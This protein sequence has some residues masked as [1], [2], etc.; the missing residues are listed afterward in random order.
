MSYVLDVLTH[1][2]GTVFDVIAALPGVVAT[3]PG[4][5][6]FTVLAIVVVAAV[7]YWKG[8]AYR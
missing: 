6:A 2:A 5:F 1:I 4:V 8:G 3:S 7:V